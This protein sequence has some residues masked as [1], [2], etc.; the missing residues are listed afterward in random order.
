MQT[1]ASLSYFKTAASLYFK[2]LQ[3]FSSFGHML[4]FSNDQDQKSV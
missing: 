4:Y 1:L 3:R 2:D